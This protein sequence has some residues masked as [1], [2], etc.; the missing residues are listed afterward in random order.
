M[1][2]PCVSAGLR[3]RLPSPGGTKNFSARVVIDLAAERERRKQ[4]ESKSTRPPRIIELLARAEEFQRMLHSGEAESRADLARRFTLSRA[5]VTQI[6]N[7]LTLEPDLRAAIATLRRGHDAPRVSERVLR[8][9][10]RDRDSQVA[11]A[12]RLQALGKGS[13]EYSQATAL[14]ALARSPAG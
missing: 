9:M 1:R 5:R 13:D 8:C 6:L 7:L 10:M 3:R 4:A 12:A 2:K 14:Q 11:L